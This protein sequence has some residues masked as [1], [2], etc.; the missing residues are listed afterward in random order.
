MRMNSLLRVSTV[1]A[2]RKER[3]NQMY[4]ESLV[5]DVIDSFTKV[6]IHSK[7]LIRSCAMCR[8]QSSADTLTML[9]YQQ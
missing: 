7:L 8:F 1:E 5:S 2:K 3:K 6:S 9:L 4:L